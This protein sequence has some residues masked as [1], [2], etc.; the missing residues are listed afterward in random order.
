MMMLGLL[1]G[2]LLPTLT[3]VCFVSLL[4]GNRKVLL[5]AERIALGCLLGLT[6]SMGIVLAAHILTG[7]SLAL[8]LFFG[9]QI[10]L[11]IISSVACLL[12]KKQAPRTHNLVTETKNHPTILIVLG[13]L[14]G[15]VVLKALIIGIVA[16]VIIAYH[17][18]NIMITRLV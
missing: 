1:I 12:R 16:V 14:A 3:G 15:F 10:G 5:T 13:C 9:L 7:I 2:L 4:E 11:L 17:I 6:M 18:I 8:P